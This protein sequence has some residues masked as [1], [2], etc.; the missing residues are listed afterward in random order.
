M[1]TTTGNAHSV[2]MKDTHT[3]DRLSDEQLWNQVIRREPGN[4]LTP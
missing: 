3:I 4:F 1:A 2:G